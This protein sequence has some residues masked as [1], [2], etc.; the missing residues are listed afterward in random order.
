MLRKEVKET[1]KHTIGF[2]CRDCIHYRQIANEKYYDKVCSKNGVLEKA[3]APVRCFHPNVYE[4]QKLVPDVL[5]QIGLLIKD[6]TTTQARVLMGVLKWRKEFEH[7]GLAFGQ[8]V[9]ICFGGDYLNN[10]Y[11]GFVIGVEKANGRIFVTSDLNKKQISRP[12]LLSMLRDSVYNVIQFRKKRDD[13]I[14]K[15]KLNDPKESGIFGT[16]IKKPKAD[17]GYEPPSM[18]Q[19]PA[20]WFDAYAK[21]VGKKTKKG[22]MEFHV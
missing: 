21:R 19:V 9:Y 12:A 15:G 14:K 6:M 7:L 2:K 3:A 18:D 11:K 1:T 17:I 8:P 16:S 22:R 10:Y 20:S 5:N 4:L 13:L